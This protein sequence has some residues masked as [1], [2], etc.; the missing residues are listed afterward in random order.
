MNVD[1]DTRAYQAALEHLPDP[2]PRPDDE[3]PL[4][5]R[6]WQSPKGWAIV[7]D[8]NNSTIG[9]F[10]TG[11][12]LLF[13]LLAG[14]LALLMR[15]QLALPLN[16]FLGEATYN[17]F[18]T[19]HGTVM[20]FLF[21]V[22]AME[23]LGVLLLPQMLAARD[24]PFP[25]LSAFAFWAYFIGGLAFFC[26]LFFGVAPDQGWTM[27]PPLS[28]HA[29]SP[30]I[31]ADFWLLGI[32]FIEISAIAG[33]VEIVV[34]I[35]RTRAP[36]MTM[37]ELP[38]FAW[39]MLVFAGM[40]IIGF[41][42]IILSTILLELER[43]LHW[44][45]FIAEL[46]GASLLWQHLF[47]FFGHP[48]VYI[49][50]L[51]AAGLMS[52]IVPTVA[53]APLLG[54]RLVVLAILS[55]AF[56]SFGVWTHHMFATGLPTLSLGVFSAASMGVSMPAGIQVF[57]WIGTLALAKKMRWSTPALFAVGSIVTFAMG[58]LTGV[59]VALVPFDW[60]AH[61]THF[62]VAHLHYVLIGGMVMPLFAAIYMWT[63]MISRRALS[64][65][66]GRWAFWLIFTGFHVTF[67]PMHV[68]G[69]AGMP[70]RAFTYQSYAWLDALNL[71]STLG[72]LL[73]GVGVCVFL[74]DLARHFRYAPGG[75][76]A[77]N[78]HDAGTLEWLPS[79]VFGVRSMPVVASV[80][81]LW[82]EPR[83]GEQVERGQWFLPDAPTGTRE[84]IVVSPIHAVPQYVMQ[85]G[86]PGWPHVL[87]AV[88]VAGFFLALTVKWTGVSLAFG[89]LA[90]AAIFAWVWDLDREPPAQPVDVGGGLRLPVGMHGPKGHAWWAMAVLN[91][92]LAMIFA[93]MVFSYF[94]LWSQAPA[95]W[96]PHNG[97]WPEPHWLWMAL[98]A[99]AASLVLAKLASWALVASQRAYAAPLLL[100]GSFLAFATAFG[101]DLWSLLATGLDPKANAYAATV[102][103]ISAL[104]GA[105]VATLALMVGY[106]LVRA[107]TGRVH[108]NRRAAF[109]VTRQLLLYAL[110]Q[111]A[112][113]LL[114]VRVFPLVAA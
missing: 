62:V 14:V 36:G 58:G 26:S 71:V 70:R 114:L 34:G 16:T 40:I 89:V 63:P 53:R 20:M 61:D 94:F 52:M 74:F 48:E 81:P 4:L 47:W 79:D 65:R 38:V 8:V 10:Y 110:A 51:P 29:Q 77:G 96:M 83:L 91:T 78:V 106:V 30:G 17:Q 11:A 90:I 42:A 46:G 86:T 44:P 21:A 88:G 87:A 24:L 100:L 103:T 102:V 72:A 23:S 107:A 80:Y 98:A 22:P 7:S 66:L 37:D 68:T 31:G 104:T 73:I 27:Y 109:D 113:G 18:F 43:A 28:S 56:L 112:A 19:M 50:F 32:G 101:I 15:L 12:A 41:P 39:A 69:M 67:L 57:A 3:L 1:H 45:F 105:L 99:L 2:R 49:I 55:I 75:G 108:A 92:V 84:T 54:Y 97:A 6:I 9:T 25:R 76:N 93:C 64:E 5:K 82:D 59:M 85:L 60:Q 33:A 13:F 111:A 95:R 35:L